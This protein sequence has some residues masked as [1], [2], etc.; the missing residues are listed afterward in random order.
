M[1]VDD[2]EKLQEIVA[3]LDPQM[4]VNKS[5]TLKVGYCQREFERWLNGVDPKKHWGTLSR[6]V[7]SKGNAI[8]ACP[9]CCKKVNLNL[10]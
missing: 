7:D 4:V 1:A 10:K 6:I 9:L 8:F 3:N 5:K 2:Y